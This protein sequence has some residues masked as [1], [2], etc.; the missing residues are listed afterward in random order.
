MR[1]PSATLALMFL[2]GLGAVTCLPGCSRSDREDAA[3]AVGDAADDAAD[4]IDDAA[5]AAADA[6][7]DA[8]DAAGDGV[9]GTTP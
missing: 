6:I 8:T 9:P 7:D 4:A 2:L 5:D 3:D 1:S